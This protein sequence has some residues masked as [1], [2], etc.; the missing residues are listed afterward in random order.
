[1]SIVPTHPAEAVA[2]ESAGK[3]FES[4]LESIYIAGNNAATI[5]C[6]RTAHKV[7]FSK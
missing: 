1:M 4:F 5:Q 2:L 3:R 6:I 7:I